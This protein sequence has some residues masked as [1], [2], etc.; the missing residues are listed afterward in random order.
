MWNDPRTLELSAMAGPFFE[1][2]VISEIIK[3]Y[4]SNG[5]DVRSRL[6]YYRDNSGKEIDL[7]IRQNGTLCPVEIKKSAGPGKDALKNFSVL[8]ALPEKRGK[9]AVICMT[10]F[11]IRLDAYN[12]LVPVGCI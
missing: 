11:I 5:L 7:L 9:G 12:Y 6:F 10:P 1:N 2:W 4:D 3:G 8:K